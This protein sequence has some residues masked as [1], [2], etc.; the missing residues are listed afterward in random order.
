MC[1]WAL[2][3]LTSLK[4]VHATYYS[5]RVGTA[6]GHGGG[7]HGGVHAV[8]SAG[9]EGFG[10]GD[11]GFDGMGQPAVLGAASPRSCSVE[12]RGQIFVDVSVDGGGRFS[13]VVVVVDAGGVEEG[14]GAEEAVSDGG[15]FGGGGPWGEPR[16]PV[17]CFFAFFSG[18]RWRWVSFLVVNLVF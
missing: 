15:E 4:S 3:F 9:E 1:F 18:G 6:E 5:R 13:G 11:G 16:P 14:G 8:T 12:R 17:L 2:F 7:H 10:E